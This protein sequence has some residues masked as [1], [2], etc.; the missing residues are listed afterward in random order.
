MVQVGSYVNSTNY[1]G[2]R[3]F[4]SNI[5]LGPIRYFISLDWFAHDESRGAERRAEIS[6][7]AKIKYYRGLRFFVKWAYSDYVPDPKFIN[8]EGNI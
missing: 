2:S 4:H 7:M 6:Y 1:R 5:F 3:F 8:G